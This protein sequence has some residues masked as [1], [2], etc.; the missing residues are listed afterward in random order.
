MGRPATFHIYMSTDPE[1][2]PVGILGEG[3]HKLGGL[4]I[5]GGMEWNR[6][7]KTLAG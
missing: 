5:L 7:G 4:R 1:V 6:K 3:H 2:N